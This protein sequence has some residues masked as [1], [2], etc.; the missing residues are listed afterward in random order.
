MAI[1]IV[2]GLVAGIAGFL[3]LTGSIRLSRSV[4]STSNFSYLTSALVG[5]IGS[6]LILGVSVALCAVFFRTVLLGFGIAEACGLVG[7]VL[8]YVVAGHVRK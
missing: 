2:V 3:P 8:V 7:A 5:I 1:A 6:L 4:T